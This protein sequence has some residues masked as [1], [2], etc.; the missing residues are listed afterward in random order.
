[1]D[2]SIGSLWKVA[3]LVFDLE[4]HENFPN[5]ILYPTDFFPHDDTPQQAM[6]DEFVKILEDFLEVKRTPIKIAEEWRKRPPKEAHGMLLDQFL[7]KSVF[8]PLCHDYYAEYSTF[9]ED[10]Q[11][12]FGKKPYAGPTNQFRL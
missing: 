6:V 12:G 8:K 5:R 9:R 10:Y 2:R 1:M 4:P 3:S 7:D 11:A